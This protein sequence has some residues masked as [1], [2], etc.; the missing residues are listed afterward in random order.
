MAV[1]LI[2]DSSTDFTSEE[3]KALGLRH[4]PLTL[5][6]GAEQ[7]ADAVDI[8]PH[9]F[10]EK[11][12][13]SKDMPTTCQV[14]PG[15]F[16]QQIEQVI[17]QGDEAVVFTLSG[18]LSGTYQSAVIAAADYPD[19][20]VVVD[21]ENATIG[22]NILVR[23]ALRLRDQGKSAREIGELLEQAKQK[24]RLYAVVDTLEYLK[25]GGRVSAAVAFAGS[26]LSIKPVLAVESGEVVIKGK[27]RGNRQGNNML[28]QMVEQGG[29][30][31]YDMPYALAYAGVSD[32]NLKAFQADTASL[33]EGVQAP[34]VIHLGSVIGAHVGP[35]AVAVAFF[36][37]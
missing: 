29:G 1:Q 22:G 6:F 7:Y 4:V 13:S 20:V 18:K 5:V 36:E 19:R 15:E 35:G 34:P 12:V 25:R 24:V 33:W 10:Y 32:E 31:D 28:K 26:L 37:K 14:T 11:L 23:Y 27:A 30:I 17:A 9:E 2:T 21:T 8:T 16:A 3:A